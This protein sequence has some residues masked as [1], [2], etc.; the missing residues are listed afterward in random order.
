MPTPKVVILRFR[1]VPFMDITGI[2]TLE[3]VIV[4][5][6]KRGVR[7][8]LCEANERV[9]AKLWEAGVLALLGEQDFHQ[10]FATALTSAVTGLAEGAD[11]AA[12]TNP[13]V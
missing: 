4:K 13:A 1:H 7:T 5:L 10:Q 6:R 8:L 3:E 9:R 12:R 11:G 2:Q